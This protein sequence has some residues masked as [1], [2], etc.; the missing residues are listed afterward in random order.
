MEKGSFRKKGPG[1]KIKAKNRMTPFNSAHEIDS[2]FWHILPDSSREKRA[3]GTF[4]LPG[5]PS[6][7][8][9]P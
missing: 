6:G 9:V 7:K 2:A 3:T 1:R 8:S 4:G 5:P